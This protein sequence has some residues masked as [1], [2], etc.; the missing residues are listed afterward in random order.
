[1][2]VVV[3][4]AEH[5]KKCEGFPSLAKDVKFQFQKTQWIPNRINPQKSTPRHIIIKLL[6]TRENQNVKGGREKR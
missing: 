4:D 2:V 1:M 3:G 6:E 5:L